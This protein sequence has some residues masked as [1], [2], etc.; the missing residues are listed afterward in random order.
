MLQGHFQSLFGHVNNPC[1][2]HSFSPTLLVKIL[3]YKITN[4]YCAFLWQQT[5][6]HHSKTIAPHTKKI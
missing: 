6:K 2:L 1:Y 3:R 5:L 4:T